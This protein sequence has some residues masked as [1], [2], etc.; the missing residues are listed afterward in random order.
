M[1]TLNPFKKHDVSEFEGVLVPLDKDPNSNFVASQHNG[2]IKT[3]H[4]EK[5]VHPD[6]DGRSGSG[7]GAPSI[8]A[9]TSV[10]LTLGQL[11]ASVDEDMAAGDQQT[12]Y[13]RKFAIFYSFGPL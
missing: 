4:D 2:S 1:W 13:D 11:R 10:G 5:S 9:G 7:D 12:A 8:R 6:S 3:D